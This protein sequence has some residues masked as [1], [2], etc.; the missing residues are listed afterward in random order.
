MLCNNICAFCCVLY[1][2]LSVNARCDYYYYIY[3][4]L[5]FHEE[6]Q[7]AATPERINYIIA[8]TDV[9]NK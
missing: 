1:Y 6:W 4:N 8:I 2:S 3:R 5:F 9:H 7:S